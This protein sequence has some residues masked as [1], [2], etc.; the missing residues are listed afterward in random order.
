MK[1]HTWY[2]INQNARLGL[3]SVLDQVQNFNQLVFIIDG[4]LE[5]YH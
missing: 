4:R 2:K 5:L 1:V 3:G